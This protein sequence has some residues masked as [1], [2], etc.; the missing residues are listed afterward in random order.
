MPIN[1]TQRLEN[2]LSELRASGLLISPRVLDEANR[3]RTRVDGRD[4]INLASNN[5]LG[6]A[7]HPFLKERA[8]QYLEKCGA[9]AGAVRTIAGTLRIHE[10]FE[11]Q[12]ADLNTRA[13]RWC[14][15]AALPPIRACWEPCSKRVTW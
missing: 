4:V 15:K 12:L 9:R 11:R 7:D 5:Y 10:D 8:R 3:A 1:L 2:D 6:F 14:C 13:A